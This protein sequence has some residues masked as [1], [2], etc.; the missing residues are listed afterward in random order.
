M[1]G[2]E[3]RM[4][5]RHYLEQE[6][7][8]SALARQPGVHRD[9]IHRWIRAGALD[10]DLESESVQ[11]GPRPPVATK[12]DAYK[13]VIE[14]RLAAY[15]ELSAVRL[16][17]EIRAA[18]YTGGYSQL[19]AFVRQVRTAPAPQPVVRFETLARKQA[20][21]RLRAVHVSL[22]RAL[23]AARGARLLARVVVSL[24]SAPG[25]AD[26]GERENA[27]FLDDEFIDAA[28]SAGATIII[29]GD[30]HLIGLVSWRQSRSLRLDNSSIVSRP[31]VR[32]NLPARRDARPWRAV[33]AL[34]TGARSVI[35][36]RCGMPKRS[37]CPALIGRPMTCWCLDDDTTPC[38]RT[39]WLSNT[40]SS[41]PERSSM[42]RRVSVSRLS[43]G[44]HPRPARRR[45]ALYS[46]ARHSRGRRDLASGYPEH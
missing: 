31:A 11:Y 29:S 42:E 23:R 43:R 8:K 45:C 20:Q 6:G 37:Q 10:R 46:N 9:T 41:S 16:L 39:A 30:R 15:P 35:C 12:L 44:R 36:G 14:A 24:L 18:G 40:R 1:F 25:Q 32:K 3:T 27:T 13:G 33:K 22:W 7:S 4:L 17:A 38:V 21:V 26:S 19:K 5:L 28:L 34:L 2:R